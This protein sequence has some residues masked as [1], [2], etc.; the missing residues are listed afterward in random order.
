MGEAGRGRSARGGPWAAGPSTPW[1]LA[2]R[3]ENFCGRYVRWTPLH[4]CVIYSTGS[5]Y[6]S[7]VDRRQALDQRIAESSIGYELRTATFIIIWKPNSTRRRRGLR[8]TRAPF[9]NFNFVPRFR[10]L[11]PFN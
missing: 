3:R 4:A 6:A 5:S 8:N 10:F 2:V 9:L 1:C 7:N 11:I